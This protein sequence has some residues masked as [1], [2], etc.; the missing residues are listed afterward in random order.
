MT[1]QWEQAYA[2]EMDPVN[3]DESVPPNVSS[4]LVELSEVVGSNDTATKC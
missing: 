4:P 3:L 2:N 1:L